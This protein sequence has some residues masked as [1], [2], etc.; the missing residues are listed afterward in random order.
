[1]G[2][3]TSLSGD[4]FTINLDTTEIGTTTFGSGSPF[5]WTFNA[6]TTDPTIA[7]ADNA[8]N[9]TAANVTVTGDLTV[10]GLSG[11]DGYVTSTSGLL[12]SVSSIPWTDISSQPNI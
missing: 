9:L 2:I 6:G 1:N 4:T 11:T 12:G 10:S 7:F 5:T 8:L 3:D